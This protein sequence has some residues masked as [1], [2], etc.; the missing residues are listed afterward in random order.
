VEKEHSV[1]DQS[2]IDEKTEETGVNLDMDRHNSAKESYKT[3]DDSF[4][5]GTPVEGDLEEAFNIKKEDVIVNVQ[6]D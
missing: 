5:R 2:K 6:K 3:E 1:E 4:D